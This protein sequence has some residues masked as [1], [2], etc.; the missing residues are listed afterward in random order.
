MNTLARKSF[1]DF[2]QTHSTSIS[3][4]DGGDLSTREVSSIVHLA[5]SFS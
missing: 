1:K 5:I 4:H 3:G 2:A